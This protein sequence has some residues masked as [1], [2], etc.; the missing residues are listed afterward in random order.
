MADRQDNAEYSVDTRLTEIEAIDP[1]AGDGLYWARFHRAVMQRASAELA[2]RRDVVAVTISDALS[3]WARAV[4]PVAAVAAALAGVTLMEAPEP[5][6][7]D[8]LVDVL[9]VPAA[10]EDDLEGELTPSIS[11]A[12]IA[13]NF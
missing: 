2:R 11:A 10:P 7:P 6:V 1:G 9:E 13:E 8:R 5:T 4:L 3:G 12:A